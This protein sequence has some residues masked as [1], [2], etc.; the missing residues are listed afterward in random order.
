M[1]TVFGIPIDT[2]TVAI[3]LIDAAALGALAMLAVRNRVFFRLGAR[4]LRRRRGR[5][6]LIVVG[7]MLGTAI[8]SAALTTGDT[9][10]NSIRSAFIRALGDIDEVVTVKGANPEGSMAADAPS[11]L[12]YF[13]QQAADAVE[14][15]LAGTGLADGVAPAI[16]EPTGVQNLR[17]RQYEPRVLLFASDPDAQR[18]FGDIVTISGKVVSLA[19]LRPAQVFL[20]EDA[21]EELSAHVGDELR[22][23][24]PE[25]PRDFTVHAIV[26]YDGTGTAGPAFLMPLIAA[27]EL[28]A[29]PGKVNMVLISNDGGAVSG[30]GRSDDVE[31]ALARDLEQAGLE[32]SLVKK[33]GLDMAQ[34]EGAAF[35]SLFTTFGTFSM[36]AGVLLIFLIFVMLAAERRSEM[37]IARAVG[38]RRG[39]LVQ[40]FVYEGTLYDLLA[41]VIGAVAGVGVAFLMVAAIAAGADLGDVQIQR[42]VQLQSVVVAFGMGL[43]LT[44]LVVAASA[45]RVSRLNISAAIRSL[46]DVTSRAAGRNTL[47]VTLLGLALGSLMLVSGLSAKQ[48][49]LFHLGVSLLIVSLVGVLRRLGAGDRLTFTAPGL[50]L[51]AWW[52]LPPSVQDMFLPELDVDFSIFLLSGVMV[53][54]GSTWV[55]MYNA[56]LLLR[57]MGATL[58]RIPSL[59]PTLKLA[60]AHPL[61]T[62][63]RTGTTLAMFTMVVFT[64]GVG[65]T[66]SLTFNRAFDDIGTFGGGYDIRATTAP[67]APVKDMAAA[68]RDTDGLEP[69][70]ITS[71]SAQSILPVKARDS[72]TPGASHEDY[73]LRGVDR[74][75]L[76]GTTYDLATVARGYSSAADVWQAMATR[77]DL[78]VVDATVVQR[79]GNYN[80]AVP[81]E[82]QLK[83]VFVEDQGFTPAPVSIRDPRTG[84]THT[85][86]VIGVLSE[87]APLFMG[88]LIASQQ[89]V[90]AAFGPVAPNIYWFKL[91]QGADPAA[92][93][94]RLESAFLNHGMQADNLRKV[95]SDNVRSSLTF[96]YII[97]GFMG[98]GLV[99]GVAAL[100][101]ISARAVVERRQEIGMLRAMGFQKRMVQAVFLLESSLIA[102]SSIVLGSFLGLT[103]AYN[104][105]SDASANP[106]WGNLQFFVPWR[107]LLIV[108]ASVYVTALL[109]TLIPARRAA[110]VYPAEALRY[111]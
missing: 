71:V 22:V 104:I 13:P 70:A 100:G 80:F 98:L 68:L 39:H 20:N 75:F 25:G 11:T 109:A 45:W 46:P 7:L 49:V 44:L 108:F 5:T 54:L 66:T 38:T 53:V 111:Q 102:A 40:M 107:E 30:A 57:G 32:L 10:S 89:S 12:R 69:G 42:T 64:I 48:G 103:L 92:A 19:A 36:V 3:V 91:R 18:D 73:V 59:A 4:N 67:V 29:Q 63:F 97:L 65:S 99:V 16:S 101:V 6:A 83:G 78:A 52:L 9:M 86:T 14:A 77:P 43:L 95:L 27:Q 110:R 82:F 8:I 21:A 41:A 105:I 51:V 50:L 60:M 87:T 2:F 33:D 96:N 28:V 34:A 24:G 17:S 90:D 84:R 58:G 79:H 62:R 88:G 85:F 26:R 72:R 37:G 31:A 15:K 61:R 23:H 35:M 55:I 76:D 1:E 93:S 74:S 81:P 47:W 94:R 106:S 56:D